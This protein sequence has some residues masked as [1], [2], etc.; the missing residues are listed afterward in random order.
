MVLIGQVAAAGTPERFSILD[1][2]FSLDPYAF[3]LARNDAD[4]QLAVNRGLARIHRTGEIE[5]IFARWFGADRASQH[6]LLSVR[7]RR[8][9]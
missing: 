9:R 6:H 8:L 7:L 3:A 1:T 5:R 2:R 4:F